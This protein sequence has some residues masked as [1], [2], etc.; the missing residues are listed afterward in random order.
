MDMVWIM[1]AMVMAPSL[2]LAAL[3]AVWWQRRRRALR[4]PDAFACKVRTRWG[5]AGEQFPRAV[6]VAWWVGG[7]LA[8]HSGRRLITTQL[9]VVAAADSSRSRSQMLVRGLGHR[10][11]STLL[12]LDDGRLLEVAVAGDDIDLLT[13]PLEPR[14]PVRRR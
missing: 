9:F 1:L 13:G 11:C 7:V 10:P 14:Q 8:M 2:W 6:S 3:P 5:G 4:T 12:I